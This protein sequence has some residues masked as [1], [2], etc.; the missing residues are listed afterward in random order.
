ML[1]CG[2][3]Q[4]TPC[5]PRRG[6]ARLGPIA[7]HSLARLSHL[8]L[9]LF[10]P[11]R[12]CRPMA[13]NHLI[14]STVSLAGNAQVISIVPSM[15]SERASVP[16]TLHQ[17]CDS[18]PRV[19]MAAGHNGRGRASQFRSL[20]RHEVHHHHHHSMVLPFRPF[21]CDCVMAKCNCLATQVSH[22]RTRVQ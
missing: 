5:P 13:V 17:S 14:K 20:I 3:M 1:F 8:R 18:R 2:W 4:C 6:I 21:A 9:A 12:H 10:V 16:G 22:R 19:E 11:S 7:P 15:A